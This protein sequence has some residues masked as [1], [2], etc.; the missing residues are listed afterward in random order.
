MSGVLTKPRSPGSSQRAKT[1]RALL[2]TSPA[3]A[4]TAARWR[5]TLFRLRAMRHLYPLLLVMLPVLWLAVENF[6]Q[7]KAKDV[8]LCLGIVLAGGAVCMA[9][10]WGIFR[11]GQRAAIATTVGTILF[12][13]Y[14]HVCD[15]VFQW[16]SPWSS[17]SVVM[18]WLA[19]ADQLTWTVGGVYAVVLVAACWAMWRTRRN[20]QNLSRF[21]AVT[22]VVAL[23]LCGLRWYEKLATDDKPP[24]TAAVKLQKSA[25]PAAPAASPVADASAVKPPDAGAAFRQ[26]LRALRP[27]IAQVDDAATPD[28]YYII[29]DGYAREDVLR[30]VYSYDNSAFIGLMRRKGFYVADCSLTNYPMTFLSL[31]SSLNMRYLDE[32][33]RKIGAASRRTSPIYR[34]ISDNQVARY[35]QAH[36]YQYV[37]FP[38][39]WGG[40]DHSALADVEFTAVPSL[41]RKEFVSTLV[42]T[43]AL[44]PLLPGIADRH[45]YTLA[46][47]QD[48][49]RISGPTFTFAHLILPHPPY[50]FDRQGNVRGDRSPNETLGEALGDDDDTSW[51]NKQGYVEQLVY[52]N[53][54]V[55][56][57]VDRILASSSVPPIII[58]QADHGSA[59]TMAPN[60][61]AVKQPRLIRE[62]MP[63]LNAYYVPENCRQ[64][65]YPTIS[66]VNSFRVVVNGVFGEELELLPDRQYFSWYSKPYRHK[67]VTEMFK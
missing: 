36:G 41:L 53:T 66:P 19:R 22:S 45:L 32:D 7:V 3:R 26:P 11:N 18:K 64:Q 35:L 13:S 63:I 61:P 21:L 16:I 57:I 14:G 28:M 4:G 29:L 50:V 25:E 5:T 24:A 17:R 20:L 15:A 51:S 54:R 52:L 48:V 47:L 56:E 10:A 60:S 23:A 44:R 2:E 49:A 59:S 39:S 42:R 38:T 43:T 6:E 46:K 12:F 33:T 8:R 40:T 31:A 1:V 30:D 27:P 9:C 37:H 34:L 58:I 67:D 65:L 62:R 55:E